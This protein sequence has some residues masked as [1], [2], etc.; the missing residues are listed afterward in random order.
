LK[1]W[2]RGR[3]VLIGD[4]A[5][6]ILPFLGL[7]AALAIEDAI[8]LP[9]ALALTADH[10][11]AF[12]AFEAARFVRVDMVRNQTLLQ[13]ELIQATDP[14]ETGLGGSPSQDVD[15]FGYNPCEVPIMI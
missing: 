5:H 11:G 10:V 2:H 13:G 3:I 15:L 7:G 14:D 8:V 1:G 12:T 4:A 6:P 9:R